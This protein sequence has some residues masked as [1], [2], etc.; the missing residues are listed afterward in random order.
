MRTRRL[1]VLP[2]NCD[3]SD[4]DFVPSPEEIAAAKQFAKNRR[5]AKRVLVNLAALK[6]TWEREDK[7][8]DQLRLRRLATEMATIAKADR[9]WIAAENERE[10]RRM[11]AQA[12]LKKVT[13]YY[14]SEHRKEALKKLGQINRDINLDICKAERLA[15]TKRGV[16]RG[17]KS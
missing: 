16:V 13:D 14:L 15:L 11:A 12:E 10:T 17:R 9:D 7:E 5:H 3:L 1:Y 8:R 6:K 4:M 2:D